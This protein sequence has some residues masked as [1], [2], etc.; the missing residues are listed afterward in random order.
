MIKK[1]IREED[2]V[3]PVIGVI[4]M[5]AITVIL[6]AVI[7]TFV[8]GLGDQVGNSAP[9]A[10]FEFS[11]SNSAY[12]DAD[13]T[14]DSVELIMVEIT[15]SNGASIEEGTVSVTVNGHPAYGIADNGAS[16]D[17]PTALWS[18]SDTISAG[19]SVTVGLY[20]DD[21]DEVVTTAGS[22]T[23]LNYEDAAGTAQE[24]KIQAPRT[25]NGD[26]TAAG[27]HALAEGDVIRVIWESPGGGSTATIAKYTV[28]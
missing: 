12:T 2:A 24:D 5:V 16:A 19:S 13:T 23:K 8:L 7:G 14:P 28:K 17:D 21:G 22:I 18:G 11:Q 3:S 26:A 9:Q 25:T 15:H 27:A 6:A 4:L 1:F 20:D 10:S